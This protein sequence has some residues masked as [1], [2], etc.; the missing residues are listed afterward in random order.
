MSRFN[1]TLNVKQTV[2]RKIKMEV[3]G[4]D[5]DEALLKANKA[6]DPNIFNSQNG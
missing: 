2:T 3:D 1:I 5:E 4:R 6:L